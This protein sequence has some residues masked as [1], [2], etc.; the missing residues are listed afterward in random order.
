MKTEFIPILGTLIKKMDDVFIDLPE[1]YYKDYAVCFRDTLT[2]RI[3]FSG[4]SFEEVASE[5]CR[6]MGWREPS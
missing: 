3:I 6:E 5:Y 4:S 2:E 1:S